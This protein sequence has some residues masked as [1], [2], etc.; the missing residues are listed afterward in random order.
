[1]A[2]GD[3][4]LALE[5]GAGLSSSVERFIERERAARAAT[6]GLAGIRVVAQGA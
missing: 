6:R 3:G 5:A 2:I 1:M 4:A